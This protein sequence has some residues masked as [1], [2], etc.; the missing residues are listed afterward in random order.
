MPEGTVLKRTVYRTP[1]PARYTTSP[2]T[3]TSLQNTLAPRSTASIL[4]LGAG[5]KLPSPRTNYISFRMAQN[6]I[7]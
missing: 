6:K 4:G 2:V 5:H 1:R 7:S 3:P